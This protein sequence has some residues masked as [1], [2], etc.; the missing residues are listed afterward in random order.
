M[1]RIADRRRV[2][3]RDIVFHGRSAI[4]HHARKPS[5]RIATYDNLAPGGIRSRAHRIG[6]QILATKWIRLS[7]SD[8]V[9][10]SDSPKRIKPGVI[11]RRDRPGRHG[12]QSACR[13]R[14]P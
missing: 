12:R 9:T 4:T 1:R 8:L 2:W 10:R 3:W 7:A 13:S 6:Q 14:H 5:D 11:R